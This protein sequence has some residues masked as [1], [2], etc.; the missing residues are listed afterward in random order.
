MTSNDL[1][2]TPGFSRGPRL[3]PGDPAELFFREWTGERQA[4]WRDLVCLARIHLSGA[5]LSMAVTGWSPSLVAERLA[6]REPAVGFEQKYFECKGVPYND[7]S[8]LGPDD[9]IWFAGGPSE[10][11]LA[12][13]DGDDSAIVRWSASARHADLLS[14]SPFSLALL[15]GADVPQDLFEDRT[16]VLVVDVTDDDLAIERLGRIR[17]FAYRPP[18]FVAHP[19]SHRV[20]QVFSDFNVDHIVICIRGLAEVERRAAEHGARRAD[21]DA[22]IVSI[23]PLVRVIGSQFSCAERDQLVKTLDASDESP[24]T[25]LRV[26]KIFKSVG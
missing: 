23:D 10:R 22:P 6:V 14:S 11:K 20:L 16:G 25:T 9:V 19:S 17:R 18:C 5:S 24:D 13:L 4:A 7:W 8:L 3:L 2:L 15:S 26:R 21:A 12:H 1:P